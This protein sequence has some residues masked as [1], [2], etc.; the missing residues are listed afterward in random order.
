MDET[1]IF[2]G[3]ALLTVLVEALWLRKI[4][5]K[6]VQTDTQLLSLSTENRRP[7]QIHGLRHYDLMSFSLSAEGT[8]R[9]KMTDASRMLYIHLKNDVVNTLIL[10]EEQALA[11]ESVELSDDGK[12]VEIECEVVTKPLINFAASEPGPGVA[13]ERVHILALYV[14]PSVKRKTI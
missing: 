1:A 2:L 10:P 3:V 12:W 7:G 13:S 4:A 6:L 14:E 11:V 8:I 5:E 9:A